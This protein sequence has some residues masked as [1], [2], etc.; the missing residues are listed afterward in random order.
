MEE[1]LQK[2]VESE[3]LTEETKK[4]LAEAYQQQVDEAVNKAIEEAKAETEAQVRAELAE[5]FVADKEA[6]I[7]AIDTKTEEYLEKEMSELKEDIDRFRDLEAEYAEKLVEAKEEM[8][9]VL[10]GDIEELVETVDKF[11]DMRIEE[12]FNELK[13][14][15]QQV[16]ALQFGKEVY[17]AFEG[18]FTQKFI[19]ENGL[20]EEIK[21]RESRLE[22]AEAKVKETT[23]VLEKL[24]RE[25]KMNEVLSPLHGKSRDVMEAILKSQ[26]TNKLEEAY[27]HFIGRVLHESAEAVVESEKESEEKPVLAEGEEVE[28]GETPVEESTVVATG[29][30]EE[31]VEESADQD[32]PAEYLAEIARL[33]SL[34]NYN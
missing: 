23:R 22:E 2:L 24:Q 1:L 6:L 16:K 7:E 18:M 20:E 25:K 5:Q 30:T 28:T 9:D 32:L 11:L 10:K 19:N 21:E 14:D 29:D 12:E 3:L 8:A 15:I 4:E 17:E 26:P 31:L 33:K 27:Q 34:V 13:E